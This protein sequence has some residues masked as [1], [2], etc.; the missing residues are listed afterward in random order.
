MGEIINIFPLPF[1]P[2]KNANL[3]GCV[4]EYIYGRLK[5]P[6]VPLGG[7]PLEGPWWLWVLLG[8]RPGENPWRLW[9]PLGVNPEK[10]P[11]DSG[12]PRC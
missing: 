8:V 4:V 1:H 7:E 5:V 9:G 10:A 11:E 2:G 3:G 12:C 6:W